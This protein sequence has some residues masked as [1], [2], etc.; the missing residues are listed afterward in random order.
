LEL[1]TAPLEAASDAEVGIVLRLF[2]VMVLDLFISTQCGVISAAHLAGS[3]QPCR[4]ALS[5]V[6]GAMVNV[7][8]HFCRMDLGL[9]P[10][11]DRAAPV[12][13]VLVQGRGKILGL[14]ASWRT[15][16]TA[17]PAIPICAAWVQDRCTSLGLAGSWRTASTAVPAIPICAAWVQDR[18]TSLGLGCRDLDASAPTV[19]SLNDLARDL[20][21][22]DT[23][24][25]RLCNAAAGS[26][27]AAGSLAPLPSAELSCVIDGNGL[28]CCVD[29]LVREGMSS[30]AGD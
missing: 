1:F 22:L 17:V 3:T 28:E 15:A 26:R 29:G 11:A 21:S 4:S 14:A 27:P 25:R 19:C 18:C 10:S 9:Q 30:F 2:R 6:T 13:A 20:D 7:L 23:S 5:E 24:I 12:T 8:F 16:S